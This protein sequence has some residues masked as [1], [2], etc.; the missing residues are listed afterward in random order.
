MN[1]NEQYEKINKIKKNIEN[2]YGPKIK[3]HKKHVE[4]IELAKKNLNEQHNKIV[5]LQKELD[6]INKTIEQH[7]ID[8]KNMKLKVK[9]KKKEITK[10]KRLEKSMTKKLQTH[11][12]NHNKLI[13]NEGQAK[14]FADQLNQLDIINNILNQWE[15]IKTLSSYNI[16]DKYDYRKFLKDNNPYFERNEIKKNEKI[17]KT[18]KVMDTY[19]LVENLL[20]D[21][22][23]LT[24]DKFSKLF[25]NK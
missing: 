20:D 6:D 21:F 2:N 13:G 16:S 15:H 4:N 14:K 1:F 8:I 11:E 22:N 19:K 23:I 12:K 17:N 25:L 18:K 5:K 7:K 10:Q 3:Q 9:E 24:N